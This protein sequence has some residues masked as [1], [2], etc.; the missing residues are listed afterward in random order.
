[1]E[2]KITK[3]IHNKREAISTVFIWQVASMR[4]GLC[5]V[6]LMKVEGMRAFG[7]PECRRVTYTG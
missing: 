1:M 2:N 6:A 7:C 3:M 4:C 5:H